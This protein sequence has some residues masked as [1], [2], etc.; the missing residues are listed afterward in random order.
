MK[1]THIPSNIELAM[2][3]AFI[4]GEGYIQLRERI[5]PGKCYTIPFVAITNCD[6]RLMKWLKDTFGGC[7]CSNHYKNFNPKWNES[8]AWRI[9]GQ[10]A[11]SVLEKCLP[12]FIIKG[13]QAKVLIAHQQ[14]VSSFG[15]PLT[16][17]ARELYKNSRSA[18][19][20][21]RDELAKYKTRGKLPQQASN[22]I[23]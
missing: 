17:V 19:L 22:S 10:Y 2:L 15:N 3:A 20:G 7:V 9:E 1:T 11:V 6:L 4:D 8:F 21:L 18:R 14:L 12:Y 13:D 5:A 16:K 23:Q